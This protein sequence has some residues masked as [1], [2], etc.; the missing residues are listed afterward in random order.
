MY[1]EKDIERIVD[2]RL[3]QVL[4]KGMGCVADH[5]REIDWDRVPAGYDWVAQDSDGS[6]CAYEEHPFPSNRYWFG[7]VYVR[8]RDGVPGT[9][10]PN[11][12]ETLVRRPEPK[13]EPAP[14]IDWSRAPDWA[15]FAAMD[16]NEKWFWY[17]EKPVPTSP[18]FW[19][20][21]IGSKCLRAEPQPRPHPGH[22]RESVVQRP[23]HMARPEIDWKTIPVWCDW[24]A[25]D[26][27]G[28]WYAYA[29]KPYISDRVSDRWSVPGS[30]SC[31]VLVRIPA[32]LS[33]DSRGLSWRD[34]LCERPGSCQ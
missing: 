27:N 34:T 4:E 15:Q 29:V 7:S 14:E 1:N 16:K 13:P 9:F 30:G 19:G 25:M 23:K 12:K 20:K 33:P 5:D 22:W 31:D 28:R 32:S 11:W 8:L 17:E 2:R 18:A 3:K 24:V 6:L 21:S 26:E 10:T